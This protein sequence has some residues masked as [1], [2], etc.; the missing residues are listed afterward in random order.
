MARNYGPSPQ[1]LA[2]LSCSRERLISSSGQLEHLDGLEPPAVAVKTREGCERN[3]ADR[4]EYGVT[5]WH[6]QLCS[7]QRDRLQAVGDAERLAYGAPNSAVP[8]SSDLEDHPSLIRKNSTE[9]NK[10]VL[11]KL[12][13]QLNARTLSNTVQ[14]CQRRVTEQLQYYLHYGL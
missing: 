12:N 3:P 10:S 13:A 4:V 8:Y 7:Q 9:K 5:L 1:P 11:A 14:T 6:R 2:S